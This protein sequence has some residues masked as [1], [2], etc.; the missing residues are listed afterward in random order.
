MCYIYILYN[1]P[2]ATKGLIN[3][4]IPTGGKWRIS[5]EITSCSAPGAT[6]PGP[7]TQFRG[8]RIDSIQIYLAKNSRKQ[9]Q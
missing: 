7:G 6:T 3:A 1:R 5:C 4:H 2:Y 9:I 8:M